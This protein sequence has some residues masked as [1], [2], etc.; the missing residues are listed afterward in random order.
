MHLFFIELYCFEKFLLP[1]LMLN[2]I[3]Q[4]PVL[5]QTIYFAR[6][7]KRPPMTHM[8]SDS[9]HLLASSE[10]SEASSDSG[11]TDG[12]ALYKGYGFATQTISFEY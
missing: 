5:S 10:Q 8:H 9:S 2:Y 4:V 3:E 11:A 6:E 7:N 12:M 1:P